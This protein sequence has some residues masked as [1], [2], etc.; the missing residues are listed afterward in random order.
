MDSNA[1][2]KILHKLK[3]F[4]ERYTSA[5][6][7][8]IHALTKAFDNFLD[9]NISIAIICAGLEKAHPDT[10]QTVLN[11]RQQASPGVHIECFEKQAAI[12]RE[13]V[14]ACARDQNTSEISWGM[15]VKPG[16]GARA[17]VE[18]FSKYFV[19]PLVDYIEDRLNDNMVV[20]GVLFRYK[21]RTEYYHREKLYDAWKQDTKR[22][23][24]RLQEDLCGYLHDQGLDFQRESKSRS[25]FADL[26][27][28]RR[29]VV[30]A[31]ILRDAN[32]KGVDCIANAIKQTYSYLV[33]HQ[34]DTAYIVVFCLVDVDLEILLP[35]DGGGGHY[36]EHNNK[37]MHL[38]ILDLAPVNT[39]SKRGSLK[40]LTLSR[41]NLIGL[42]ADSSTPVDNAEP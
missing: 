9:D 15:R 2:L 32:K 5:E 14:R 35:D 10:N 12:A 28:P 26:L 11:W 8:N 29:A 24:R 17:V 22:G 16:S 41:E 36:L 33:D 39:A 37:A 1:Q 20:L 7:Y 30:E 4:A 6:Y 40:R 31:K 19:E 21:Q 38:V 23:E 27:V 18:G 25:G 3:K 34:V 13:V 42:F